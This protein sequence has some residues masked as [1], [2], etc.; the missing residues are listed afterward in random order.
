ML[1]MNVRVRETE[2]IEDTLIIVVVSRR[3]NKSANLADM[4]V[5][6]L[7]ESI[8]A[9][10][11]CRPLTFTLKTGNI[12]GTCVIALLDTIAVELF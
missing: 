9:L 12:D 5:L 3:F 2:F 7:P 11:T 8:N 10:V 1:Y 6:L 4:N